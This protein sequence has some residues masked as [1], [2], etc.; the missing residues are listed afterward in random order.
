MATAVSLQSVLQACFDV[1]SVH[2][3]TTSLSEAASSS[4]VKQ[5]QQAGA[6]SGLQKILCVLESLLDI[7]Y[8]QAW[9]HILPMFSWL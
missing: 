4:P 5:Q 2:Q 9:T 8:Q 6:A 7:R 1:N 3:A